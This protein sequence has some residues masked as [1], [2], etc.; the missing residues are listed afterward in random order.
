VD[1]Q[2]LD[3]YN[4]E[5]LYMRE[6][7]AEFAAQHPKVARR[8]GMH[9]IDVA[10]PY[11]ERLIEAFCLLS[12][13][14][15]IKLDAQYPVFTQRLL[16]VIYPNYI[17][18]TPAMSV[19]QLHPSTTEGDFTRGVTVPR[20]TQMFARV[21]DGESTACE[22]HTT[23]PI[24]LWPLDIESARLTGAP[25]D[26]P[27]LSR[28]VP[29]HTQVR[30]ALRITLHTRGDMSFD[31]LEGLDEL[32]VF[33]RG[34]EQTASHLFEL[35]HGSVVGMLVG[36]AGQIGTQHSVV[37][38]APIGSVGFTPDESALPH[39]W[40]AFHGHNLL[41][42]YFSCPRRFHFF[43]LRHLREGLA[44]VKGP[45]AEI[46][47]LLSNAPTKLVAHVDA[48][49]FALFCTPIVNLFPKR[50]D[51]I[52]AHAGRH[53]FHLVPDRTH[54]V[55]Y[56]VHSVQCI[57]GQRSEQSE[58]LDFRPLF[59]TLNDDEGNYGRYFS[60]R[61]QARLISDQARRYG[62]RTAYIGSE[63][64]VSLVDQHE[65]PYPEDLRYLSVEAMVTNRDLP[66]L[67]QPRDQGDL[68]TPESLPLTGASLMFAPSAPRPAFAQGEAAWRL[69]RLLSF[70]YL[71]LSELD[72]RRGG[73]GLRDMLR[74]FAGRDEA[75]VHRQ[76]DNL[77]GCHTTPVTRRLPGAGPIIYGRGVRCRLTVD[78]TGF[79]G[80]SPFLF[81]MVLDHF[82]ARH[83]STNVFTETELTSLQRGAIHA[84]PAR[85]GGR[86]SV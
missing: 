78:E 37:R 63:V 67:M 9:G 72:G 38:D 73:Q 64:F 36:E 84:W 35:L 85:M 14:T 83:V 65:A 56:E 28:L 23:Q 21:P 5:L 47:L 43:V 13:R 80:G 77:V 68:S 17:A 81:G 22:F 86:G 57:E 50:T 30:G 55:D 4:E 33:L 16:E 27:A 45:R 1:P 82:L 24:T 60:V 25:P 62:T 31:A 39:P 61:R 40:N 51:R 12:A 18:P 26:I 70:N 3:Y 11:V 74:L 79:S 6:L 42:E 52:E 66:A 71:P 15:R 53:E 20:H 19:A 32:P 69:I 2:L 29:S 44:R 41:H 46:V 8:L 59:A 48:G 75:V 7:G 54:P 49:Q 76:I 10:D 58:T 34:A